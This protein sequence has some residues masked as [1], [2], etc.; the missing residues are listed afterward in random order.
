MTFRKR[1]LT[2]YFFQVGFFFN[3][4]VSGMESLTINLLFLFLI[5]VARQVSLSS[6]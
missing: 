4:D 3:L 2:L 6:L 5:L 1:N